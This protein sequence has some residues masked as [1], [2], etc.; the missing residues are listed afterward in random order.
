M[1]KFYGKVGFL[2]TVE[3][4]PIN[5]PGVFEETYVDHNCFGDVLEYN[6]R[7]ENANGLNDDIKVGNKISIVMDPYSRDNF[8][9]IR[10]VEWLGNTLKVTNVDVKYPRLI[11]SLGGV[12][13]END[14]MGN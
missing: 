11:L 4:D 2:E 5:H 10:Y 3:T 9:K 12:Y 8:S 1:A 6:S 7:W 13:N 14:A